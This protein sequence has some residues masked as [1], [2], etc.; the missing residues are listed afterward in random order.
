[1]GCI[2][3]GE[4]ELNSTWKSR[5]QKRR[6]LDCRQR[7]SIEEVFLKFCVGLGQIGGTLPEKENAAHQSCEQEERRRWFGSKNVGPYR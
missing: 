5:S 3:K 6:P 2:G 7:P 1:V 4:L